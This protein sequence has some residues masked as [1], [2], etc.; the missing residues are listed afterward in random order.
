[1]MVEVVVKMMEVM[2]GKM[3]VVEVVGA[4]CTVFNY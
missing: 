2:V 1:M 4:G 3:T